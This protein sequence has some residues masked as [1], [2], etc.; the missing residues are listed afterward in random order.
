MPGPLA[1]RGASAL[2]EAQ[3]EA[4]ERAER[5][6]VLVAVALGFRTWLRWTAKASTTGR[7]RVDDRGGRR[8]LAARAGARSNWDA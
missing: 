2:R 1:F 7:R 5:L 3:V 4:L 6:R 8:Y